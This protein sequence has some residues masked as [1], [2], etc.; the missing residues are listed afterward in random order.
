MTTSH[1]HRSS[2]IPAGSR[3]WQTFAEE[4]DRVRLTPAALEAVRNLAKAWSATGDEMAALMGVSSST[5]D[6]I[7]AGAWSQAL[8]QDQ[9]TRASAI[10]GIFKGLH[11][12]FA[13][14]MADRWIRLRNSG[15]LFGNRTPI[16]TMIDGGIPVM[17]DVRRY[18]DALRGGL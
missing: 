4:S 6:R 5:W 1:T 16:E 2:F 13:D 14:S 9:L 11:L 18:V 3:P 10:I 15:Q 8:S 17:I 7:K 12:L